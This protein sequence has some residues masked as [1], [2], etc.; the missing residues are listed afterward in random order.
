[1]S[2]A[3]GTWAELGA[4]FVGRD[5]KRVQTGAGGDTGSWRNCWDRRGVSI[6]EACVE[7]KS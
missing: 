5:E 3:Y 4:V 7:S 6:P 1:V 2:I